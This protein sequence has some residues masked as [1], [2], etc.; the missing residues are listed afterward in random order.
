M[1]MNNF[2]QQFEPNW[3]G[4][5]FQERMDWLARKKEQADEGELVWIYLL[6]DTGSDLFKIGFTKDAE[7]R[8]TSIY[9]QERAKGHHNPDLHYLFAFKHVK[10]MEWMLHN[11]VAKRRVRGEWFKLLPLDIIYLMFFAQ[12]HQLRMGQNLAFAFSFERMEVADD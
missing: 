6:W 12:D 3:K 10:Q 2:G 11:Q 5:S 7:Q 1:L 9:Y 8:K 4:L